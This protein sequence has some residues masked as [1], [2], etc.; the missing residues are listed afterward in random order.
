V[1][2][3]KL[4]LVTF[5]G[6]VNPHGTDPRYALYCL[7]ATSAGGRL[8]RLLGLSRRD[9]V[10]QGRLNLCVGRWSMQ[11]ARVHARV[12]RGEHRPVVVLLGRKVVEAFFGAT[13]VGVEGAPAFSL[14]RRPMADPTDYV[15]LPHPSGLCREWNAPSARPRALE[16]LRAAAPGVAWGEEQD[17]DQ[18][19]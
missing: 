17:G 13:V 6:E 4:P 1:T 10:A 2:R 14:L 12:I 19:S 3:V 8:R 15:V 16:L 5:V 9:Y 18:V 7:P 11:E